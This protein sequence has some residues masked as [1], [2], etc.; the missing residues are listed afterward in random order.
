[1]IYK[2]IN[3]KYLFNIISKENYLIIAYIT[4]LS[5]DEILEWITIKRFD[6]LKKL[7]IIINM[8]KNCISM[9]FVVGTHWIST[10]KAKYIPKTFKFH[11]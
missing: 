2:K 4:I 9:R 8:I 11:I 1:M 7:S 6:D 10:L 3:N 5:R